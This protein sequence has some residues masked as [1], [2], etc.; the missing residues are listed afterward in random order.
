MHCIIGATDSTVSVIWIDVLWEACK[1]AAA[2]WGIWESWHTPTH[3]SLT[4]F[5]WY[6]L[7]LGQNSSLDYSEIQS[8]QVLLSCAI[9]WPWAI[10]DRA[11]GHS[12]HVRRQSGYA[13]LSHAFT[14]MNQ[15][16]NDVHFTIS[17]RQD[18]P[19]PNTGSEAGGRISTG[20]LPQ[21]TLD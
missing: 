11:R 12:G 3:R 1:C 17:A 9:H 7:S 8:T 5:P 20:F 18:W 6:T 10:E 19:F 15:N 21:R 14:V 13:S 2:T 4:A 16:K